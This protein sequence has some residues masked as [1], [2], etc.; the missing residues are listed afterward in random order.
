[1]PGVLISQLPSVTTLDGT[2]SFVLEQNPT[3]VPVAGITKR[4]SSANLAAFLVGGFNPTKY[5]TPA[6]LAA[7]TTHNWNPVGLGA[8][9][10]VRMSSGNVIVSVDGLQAPTLS[11]DTGYK[12]LL[13]C[14]TAEADIQLVDASSSTSASINQFLVQHQATLSLGF[15]GA[16]W[17][18]YDPVSLK[19]R[20]LA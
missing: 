19:W 11:T 8:A 15:Q 2:E 13:N 3:P 18:W 14:N 10:V 7:G 16:V 6:A 20:V 4:I 9:S 1:M 12:L 17:V 5:I